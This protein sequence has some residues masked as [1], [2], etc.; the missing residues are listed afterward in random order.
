[1]IRA[2]IDNCVTEHPRC[3]IHKDFNM[4]RRLLDVSCTPSRDV[5]LWRTN[6]ERVTYIALS[7]CWGGLKPPTTTKDSEDSRRL[8][9]P[10]QDLPRTYQDVIFLA[11]SLR[12]DHVWI[13]A[14]CIVQDDDEDWD[15]ETSRMGSIFRNAL[16]VAVAADATN[17]GAGFLH[18]RAPS[19]LWQPIASRR[20]PLGQ[21]LIQD[22]ENLPSHQDE[23]CYRSAI[24]ARAWTYQERVMACRCVVFRQNEIFWECRT[25]CKCECSVNPY[26]WRRK[27]PP[28]SALLPDFQPVES[29]AD[30]SHYTENDLTMNPW[31]YWYKAIDTFSP[32]DIT[33]ASDRLPALSAIAK[34]IHDASGAEYLAGLWR[35]NLI[36][37]LAWV[38]VPQSGNMG[39][40][41][42]Q[43]D[44]YVAPSW[45]WVAIHGRAFWLDRANEPISTEYSAKVCEAQCE[46]M[47]RNPFGAVSAGHVLIEGFFCEATIEVTAG[48]AGGLK[49]RED[50][51]LNLRI[52]LGGDGDLVFHKYDTSSA[53]TDR[54]PVRSTSMHSSS[55]G[56]F[57]T[58]QRA[59]GT[60]DSEQLACS[61][62][63]RL[64]WLAEEYCLVLAYSQKEAGAF[65]RLGILG[66]R[67][68]DQTGHYVKNSWFPDCPSH[69]DIP[70]I[71]RSRVKII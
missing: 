2:W 58:L 42:Q 61:G 38:T 7:Y 14:L 53:P 59:P 57:K 35:T 51:R 60:S 68:L 47:A 36:R 62:Q 15:R 63:V 34:V 54:L 70:G 43:Y 39:K 45:S 56:T 10:L 1:M 52:A 67:G 41:T 12:I 23:A 8:R 46:T 33:R 30:G 29:S 37:Q 71:Q 9:I 6:G 65:E 55:G 50:H 48:L 25:E 44:T 32:T 27:Y 17:M 4:P 13:D 49:S 5:K 18:L 66:D 26:G 69:R 31:S 3:L 19:V 20:Q 22:P 16:L 21:I 24:T 64:L 11:Q 40:P 28:Q